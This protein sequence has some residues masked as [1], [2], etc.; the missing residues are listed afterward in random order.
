MAQQGI[1]TGG[2]RRRTW[3]SNSAQQ[4]GAG[5]GNPDFPE[6]RRKPPISKSDPLKG[7]LLRLAYSNV[8][9]INAPGNSRAAKIVPQGQAMLS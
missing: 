8:G 9:F 7:P 2:S 1:R 5:R 6:L 4:I 3:G